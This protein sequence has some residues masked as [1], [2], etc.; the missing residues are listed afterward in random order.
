MKGRLIFWGIAAFVL[1]AVLYILDGFV[2]G[3]TR[4]ESSW[5][6]GLAAGVALAGV[7]SIL[8]AMV[9]PKRPQDA[10]RRRARR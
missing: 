7:A 5:V 1:A 8:T 6:M 9:W 4:G 2:T 3:S 10:A